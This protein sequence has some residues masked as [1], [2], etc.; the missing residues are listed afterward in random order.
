MTPVIFADEAGCRAFARAVRARGIRHV[1][2][3]RELFAGGEIEHC[4][5]AMSTDRYLPTTG[6]H[7]ASE[8][9]AMTAR[10]GLDPRSDPWSHNPDR[11]YR[12]GFMDASLSLLRRIAFVQTNPRLEPAH[13][14]TIAKALT[15]ADAE[16]AGG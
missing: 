13:C 14:A 16:C 1:T 7:W 11:Q 9:R 3:S 6:A 15:E 5:T 2:T 12:P 10:V 4:Y 8:F